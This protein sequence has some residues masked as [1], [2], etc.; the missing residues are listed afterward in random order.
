MP[1]SATDL[2]IALVHAADVEEYLACQD[3]L[4]GFAQGDA[5]PLKQLVLDPEVHMVVRQ[6]AL[7]LISWVDP[8]HAGAFFAEIAKSE[9]DECLCEAAQGLQLRVET[10]ARMLAEHPGKFD[11]YIQRVRLGAAKALF[12]NRRAG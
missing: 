10:R 6:D 7:Q 11:A 5:E 2:L 4:I 1:S 9:L 3:R 12:G 8:D